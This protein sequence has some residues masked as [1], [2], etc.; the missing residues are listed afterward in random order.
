MAKLVSPIPQSTYITKPLTFHR[1][2]HRFWKVTFFMFYG[3]TVFT[4]GWI[5]RCF[6]SR[7]PGN[8]NL[9]I[10]QYVLVLAGPPIYSA[11]EYNVLG[12]LMNY[13][14][15]HTP[16]NP[17]RVVYFFIYLGALVEA[18]TAAG[19]V[20]MASATDNVSKMQKGAT[21]VAVAVVLQGVVEILFITLVALMHYRAVRAKML[22]PN[23]R[24]ICIML[25]GTSLLVLLR[26]GYR[27]A[28]KFSLLNVLK[29]GVCEGG[30]RTVLRNEWYIYAFDAAPM[31]LYTYWLNIVHPGR[32]LPR[33]PKTYLDVDKIE[34][35][36]PGWIDRRTQL[37]TFIDPFDLG[38]MIKGSPAHEKFW[39]RP[40]EWPESADGAKRTKEGHRNESVALLSKVFP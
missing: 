17:N 20:S 6:S 27:A 30:C 36:G 5:M 19:G 35:E 24:S 14:P 28:E 39:L 9:Y 3:G 13:L 26:C 2:H 12:R 7:D 40:G 33:T 25:Y 22:T 1:S 29:S 23:V 11:A 16:L 21:L 15:M 38:G 31:V 4:A 37:E 32:F 10:A 8:L 34:R 18:L